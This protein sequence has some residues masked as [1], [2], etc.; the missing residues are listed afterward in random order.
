MRFNDNAR[1]DTSQVQDRRGA[2]GGGAQ[3]G[4]GFRIGKGGLA[5][6]GGGLGLLVVL[7]IVLISQFSGGSSG[8]DTGGNVLGQLVG[9]GNQNA[10][11]DNS[12]LAAECKTGADANTKDDCAVVAVIN[13]VQ[14]YWAEQLARSGTSYREADTV[15]F[16]GSTSTGCGTGS[17][18]MGP[19]Y[20]PTDE[21][22]TSTSRSGT[23]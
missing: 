13:S 14:A 11:A 1:L 8:S 19:F 5:A 4:G 21:R 3:G 12:Q 7:A 16:T 9:N 23:S 17:T 15:F 6:G 10:S 18:G 20:C 2:S 22:S